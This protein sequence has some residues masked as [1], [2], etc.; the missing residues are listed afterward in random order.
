MDKQPIEERIEQAIGDVRYAEENLAKN[1]QDIHRNVREIAN[2]HKKGKVTD[3]RHYNN[4]LTRS[5]A[6]RDTY[7]EWL[8]DAQE[9]LTRLQR[10]K[11]GFGV[12]EDFLE[13]LLQ[14]DIGWHKHLR[15]HGL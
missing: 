9:R 12:F 3:V 14:E 7:T 5:F 6:S 13:E 4:M 15:S 2:A 8:E 11:E 1:E 10:E